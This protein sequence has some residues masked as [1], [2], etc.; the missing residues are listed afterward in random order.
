MQINLITNGKFR[1]A[2]ALSCLLAGTL[3]LSASATT[4]TVKAGG[5]GNFTTIQACATAMAA[6]DTCTVFVGTYNESVTVTAGGVSNYKTINVN[7][8]D[9][10]SVLGFTLNSHTQL[11]G[12]C[13]KP[14]TPTTA[15]CGFFISN[16][17][18]PTT[19]CVSLPNGTT[20]VYIRA[21]TIYACGA[22][23]SGYPTQV[24]F[25]YIQ[26]NTGSYTNV[27][28]ATV[29]ATCPTGTGVGNIL[30]LYG[31]HFLVEN[32]DFAHYTLA[33][34]WNPQNSITRNNNFHDQIEINNSGNCHSDTFFSDPGGTNLVNNTANV[35][36]GNFQYNGQGA[37]AKG[38]LLQAPTCSGCNIAIIRFNTTS[39]IGSGSTTNDQ[40]WANVKVYNNTTVDANADAGTTGLETDNSQDT[41]PP[42]P[43][44]LNQIYYYNRS[45][46]VDVSPGT[47][48]NS[49]SCNFGHNLAFCAAG[50]TT[51]YG[52]AYQ[53]GLFTGDA[54]NK[55]T[56]PKFVNYVSP[57]SLSNDYH[58]QSGSPAITAGTFLTTVA[59]GD[60]GSGTSL[61]L[62]DASYF[63]DGYGLSN[64]YSTVS[65]DCISV[66][67]V[68]NHICITAVNYSTN[69]LTMASG[70]SRSNGDHVWLYSKS[71]GTV[72]L[73]GSAPDLGAYPFAPSKGA[74]TPIF[75][76]LSRQ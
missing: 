2:M 43:S 58:L 60:S 45:G 21:N 69:T 54:G 18:S 76:Q 62:T 44:V 53:S 56:D 65:G 24:S 57:G 31:D 10:V 55:V 23:G 50:C 42:T 68:G 48:G 22:I 75:A 30:N 63:Q 66:T 67:T 29:T 5:G 25:I 46:I 8:S 27:T 26:G 74:G 37:N 41:N 4:F 28:T 35:Y 40:N 6:G 13:P 51:I 32:N 19:N 15:S 9:I 36:E 11:V 12:N 1:Q 20:D 70:F 71:D 61:V 38:P 49:N 47:C 64:A 72:V 34:N 16:P 52:H 73:T 39:R 33:L 7:G 3:A 17:S 59:A 14:A